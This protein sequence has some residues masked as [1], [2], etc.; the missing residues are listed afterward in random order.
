MKTILLSISLALFQAIAF[1][2][3][4][5]KWTLYKTVEGVEIYTM[6]ADCYPADI[7]S[8]KGILVKVVNTNSYRCSVVWDLA[9][10]YN[11]EKQETGV[12]DGE[13]RFTTTLDVN[14]EV[15]GSCDSPSGAFYI[16][17]DFIVYDSPTKLTRFELENITIARI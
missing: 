16:F 14:Q 3:E 15:Q 5:S 1:T 2:Q 7:P 10:W 11:N 17:K 13:N 6:E 12:R 4:Q 9:V 8:Q